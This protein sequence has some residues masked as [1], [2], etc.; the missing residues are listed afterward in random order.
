MMTTMLLLMLVLSRSPQTAA[1]ATVGHDD[2]V[3]AN[4]KDVMNKSIR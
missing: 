2:Q 1:A 4:R 3:D